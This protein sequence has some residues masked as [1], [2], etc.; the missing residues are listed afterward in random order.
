M[1]CDLEK[2]KFGRVEVNKFLILY[3]I[4]F[5]MVSGKLFYVYLVVGG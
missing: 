3:E 4:K 1:I 2:L 5:E